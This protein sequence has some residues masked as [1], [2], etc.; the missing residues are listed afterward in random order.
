MRYQNIR[1][2]LEEFFDRPNNYNDPIVG[3][4]SLK[5]CIGYRDGNIDA[6]AADLTGRLLI[7]GYN[8]VRVQVSPDRRKIFVKVPDESLER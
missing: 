5:W 2:Y 7:R 3:G 1:L 4:R 6:I 8:G